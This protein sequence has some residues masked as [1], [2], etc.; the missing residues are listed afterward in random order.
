MKKLIF[1]MICMTFIYNTITGQSNAET[2]NNPFNDQINL[3]SVWINEQMEY[4]HVPGIGVGIIYDQD[5]IWSRGFGYADLEKNIPFTPETNFRMASITKLF[6]S[7]AIMKLRDQGKLR[8]DDPVKKHLDW[9]KI[10]NPFADS[11]ASNL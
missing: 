1:F 7:T 4:Y 3:L 8:L 5:L 11:L 9:F 6:T 10:R 2:K